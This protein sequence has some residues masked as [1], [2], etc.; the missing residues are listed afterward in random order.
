MYVQAAEFFLGRRGC[1]LLNFIKILKKVQSLSSTNLET[2]KINKMCEILIN[3]FHLSCKII[4]FNTLVQGQFVFTTGE[5]SSFFI[6]MRSEL[7]NTAMR[8][9][10]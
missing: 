8:E 1:P 7:H 3:V 10:L 6:K 9:P 4:I 5:Y 2:K